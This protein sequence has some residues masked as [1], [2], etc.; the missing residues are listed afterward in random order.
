MTN[1]RPVLP[2][3]TLEQLCSGLALHGY[4]L[5]GVHVYN[6]IALSPDAARMFGLHPDSSVDVF[7]CAGPVRVTVA[8]E[9]TP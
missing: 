3:V 1:N 4:K 6:E 2:P 5:T 8:K 9:P 7:T